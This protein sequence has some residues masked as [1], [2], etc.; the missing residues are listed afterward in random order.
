MGGFTIKNQIGRGLLSEVFLGHL[1]NQ[2]DMNKLYAIKRMQKQIVKELHLLDNIMMEKKVLLESQSNFIINFD[3]S[4]RDQE[5]YYL[6]LEWAQGGDL[7]TIIKKGSPRLNRYLQ[8]GEH[9]IR[10]VLGCVIWLW[11]ICTTKEWSTGISS[12]K[13]CYFVKMAI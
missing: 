5:Y 1:T 8:T 3:S 13:T 6:V 10:F 4:F 12:Q 7:Y 9:G 11:S 2:K